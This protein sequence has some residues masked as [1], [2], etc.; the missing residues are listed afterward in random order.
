MEAATKEATMQ[1]LTEYRDLKVG[2]TVT[3]PGHGRRDPSST[4]KLV[5][6]EVV[7]FKRSGPGYFAKVEVAPGQ[8]VTTA[9]GLVRKAAV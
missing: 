9:I 5:A 6:I 1:G 3:V 7:Q 2:D 4:G 8:V